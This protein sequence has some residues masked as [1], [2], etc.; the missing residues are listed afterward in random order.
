[1]VTVWRRK[2]DQRALQSAFMSVKSKCKATV[3]SSRA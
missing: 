1:M 3:K 2:L